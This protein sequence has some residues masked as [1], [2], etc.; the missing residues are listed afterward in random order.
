MDTLYFKPGKVQD[1]PLLPTLF[2]DIWSQESSY[3]ATIYM[4]IITP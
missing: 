2:F 4:F 1:N 3:R